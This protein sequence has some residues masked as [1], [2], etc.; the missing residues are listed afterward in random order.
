MDMNI[1]L[2]IFNAITITTRSKKTIENEKAI[3]FR[4]PPQSIFNKSIIK[5]K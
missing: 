1:L 4:A 5:N 2:K 3:R